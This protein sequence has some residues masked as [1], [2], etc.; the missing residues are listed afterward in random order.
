MKTIENKK[1]QN[2]SFLEIKSNKNNGKSF[3]K[4]KKQKTIVLFFCK[5]IKNVSQSHFMIG[6]SR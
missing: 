5:G 4:E 2:I 3:F 6:V 1:N